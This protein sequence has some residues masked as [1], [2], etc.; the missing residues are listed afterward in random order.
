MP[1]YEASLV[2]GAETL[3]FL[4][5]GSAWLQDYST[6]T[7]HP[8]ATAQNVG[9]LGKLG[10]GSG[11]SSLKY[12]GEDQYGTSRKMVIFRGNWVLPLNHP[13]PGDILKEEFE[14]HRCSQTTRLGTVCKT[15]SF[16]FHRFL[17][18]QLR[19]C[20]LPLTLLFVASRKTTTLSPFT[21]GMKEPSWR[22]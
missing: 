16:G 6:R 15:T 17:S 1:L 3:W 7:I 19:V 13:F 8:L 21:S 2:L 10:S 4:T 12:Q 5:Q 20:F 18:S 11:G 9:P 14:S 22:L